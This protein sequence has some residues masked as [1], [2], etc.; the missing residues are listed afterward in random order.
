MG[1]MTQAKIAAWQAKSG[2]EEARGERLNTLN[3]LSQLAFDLIRVVELEKSGIRDGDGHWH[4][5]DPLTG[6]VLEI[7][8]LAQPFNNLR[9]GRTFE[10]TELDD[11]I[12]F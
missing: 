7:H 12:P 9:R 11:E 8:T 4:G 5:S 6:T 2:I 1:Q 3:R 10:R